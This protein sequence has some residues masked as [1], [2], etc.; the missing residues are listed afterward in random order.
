MNS[1]V[2]WEAVQS[3]S[4]E[5]QLALAFR[6]WDHLVENGWHPEPTD[7]LIAELDRRLAA[8]DANPGNVRTWDQILERIRIKS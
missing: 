1:T 6:L 4:M 3:L 5:D 2:A 7:D 8:H